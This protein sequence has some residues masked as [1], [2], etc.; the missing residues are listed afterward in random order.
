MG[1]QK[2]STNC[3]IRYNLTLSNLPKTALIPH[4]SIIFRA[5]QGIGGAGVYALAI[6]CIYEIAPKTK[7]PTYSGLMSFC[8]VLA[9][10]IGPI[11]GGALAQDSAWPWVFLIKCVG[12]QFLLETPT[13]LNV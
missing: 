11:I 6:L 10:L 13:D 2:Q 8:L 7:L 9:S 5:L 4:R 1:V 12:E 3:E